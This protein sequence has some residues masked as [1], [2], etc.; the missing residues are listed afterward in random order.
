MKMPPYV[1]A[2]RVVR[3]GRT[4]CRL[5]F[6]LFLLWPLAIPLL[7]LT[8]IAALL[9]DGIRLAAGRR[10]RSY[11]RFAT[12]VLAVVG[13]SRG[14]EVFIEDEARIFALKLI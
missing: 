8:L 14:V 9:V 10:E 2:M 6:P 5:W 3:E 11:T 1:V 7:V 13:E 12:G 4:K